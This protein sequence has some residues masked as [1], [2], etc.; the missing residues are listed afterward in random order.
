M[1]EL[2]GLE[3]LV[4]LQPVWLI[5]WGVVILRYIYRFLIIQDQ[6]IETVFFAEMREV[7]GNSSPVKRLRHLLLILLLVGF[8][9]IFAHPNEK[10]SEETI[11]KKW[12]DIVL[13]LD[14]SQSMLASDFKPDRLTVAKSVMNQFVWELEADRLGLVVFAGK[15]FTSV[16]LTFDY[17]FVKMVIA[18]MSTDMINQRVRW[19]QGTAIG[20]AMLAWLHV[21]EKWIVQEIPAEWE[22][23][24]NELEP[25]IE[26]DREQVMVVLTDGEANV[27]VDPTVVA[28][29]AVD[30]SVQVYTIGIWSQKWWFLT[31]QD[32]FNPQQNLRQKIPGVDEKTLRSIAQQTDARYRRADA[33]DTFE[34]VF[35]E[36][37]SLYKTEIENEV[38]VQYDPQWKKIAL[39]MSLLLLLLVMQ[40][41]WFGIKKK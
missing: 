33:P 8:F 10:L 41:G 34:K 29:L 19:L 25:S 9:L 28:E 2:L 5:V 4:F 17:E 6:G 32:P 1:L 30:Q 21:L 31:F 27:W 16:P 24:N 36:L 22:S 15:P 13:V 3:E 39:V 35:Q 20:D 40:E 11:T 7:F 14:I 18:D 12:I 37:A 26:S 23:E 38:K